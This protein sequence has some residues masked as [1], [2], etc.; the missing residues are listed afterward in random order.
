MCVCAQVHVSKNSF[1]LQAMKVNVFPPKESRFEYASIP[2]N[3]SL[4]TEGRVY[5]VQFQIVVLK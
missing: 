5:F 4:K 1:D 3:F 2:V